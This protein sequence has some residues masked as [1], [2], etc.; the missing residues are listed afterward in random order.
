M[1]SKEKN[2]ITI[3]PPDFGDTRVVGINS[4][5][6]DYKLVWLLNE[7]LSLKL[8]RQDDFVHSGAIYPYYHCC[9]DENSPAYGLLAVSYNKKSSLN[10]SPRLDY[11]FIVRYESL[12]HRIV[13]MSEK[14]KEIEGIN[15]A[16]L[17]DGYMDRLESALYDVEQYDNVIR[18]RERRL[19]SPE[20][21]K[22][23]IRQRNLIL[24][25][26]GD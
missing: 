6:A 25:I 1:A 15:Y 17:M 24:G 20:H 4:A 22:E 3:A 18:T 11:L 14:I 23:E 5:L 2:T 8:M 9:V 19:N 10:F 13:T 7:K 21:A 26:D 16:Y 12:P